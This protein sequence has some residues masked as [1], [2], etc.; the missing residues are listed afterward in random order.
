MLFHVHLLSPDPDSSPPSVHPPLRASVDASIQ[1]SCQLDAPPSAPA[2]IFK[3]KNSHMRFLMVATVQLES[4][5][6]PH[7]TV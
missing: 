4:S 5:A 6:G 3:N 1:T 7:N 2:G